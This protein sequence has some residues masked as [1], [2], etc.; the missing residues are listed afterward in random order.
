MLPPRRKLGAK[1]AAH[2][3]IPPFYGAGAKSGRGTQRAHGRAAVGE[4]EK[5]H[6]LAVFPQRRK[7]RR[8]NL[9][10]GEMKNDR[11]DQRI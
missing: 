8:K 2:G 5:F 9:N 1:P 4:G 11:M 10:L 3:W 7:A 6:C